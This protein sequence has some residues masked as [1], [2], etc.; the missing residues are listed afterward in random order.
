LSEVQERIQAGA[1][2]KGNLESIFKQMELE[3]PGMGKEERIQ[4]LQ[5]LAPSLGIKD[6]RPLLAAWEGPD[7]EKVFAELEAGSPKSLSKDFETLG[8]SAVSASDKFKVFMDDLR[9][10]KVEDAFKAI[11]FTMEGDFTKAL[12][13]LTASFTSMDNII[14]R[15]G[16]KLDNLFN[17][18]RS[19]P[20]AKDK[21]WE[22]FKLDTIPIPSFNSPHKPK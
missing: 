12:K 4:A 9:Y 5:G 8:E 1:F 16:K 17:I 11:T 10:T 22:F 18:D 13:S 19:R 6:I 14:D 21:D 20:N 2:G 15:V 3:T 7:R